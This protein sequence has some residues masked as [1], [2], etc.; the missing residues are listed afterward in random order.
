MSEDR[1]KKVA[2]A[3]FSDKQLAQDGPTGEI[4]AGEDDRRDF[5]TLKDDDPSDVL[6]KNLANATVILTS[7]DS[8]TEQ[9][10]GSYILNVSP[11]RRQDLAP[12]SGERFGNQHTGGW[13][14]GFMVGPDI[15]VTAGHCGET[16]ADI[17]DTAYV[18]G[19]RVGSEDDPGTTHFSADQVYF[20][21]E[22]IAF[23]L[24][25]SGDF[26]IVRVDRKITAADATPVQVRK[27]GAIAA[28][29]NVG[30]IGYPSGLPVKIAFGEKTVVRRV[31]DPWLICNLDTYG[32]NS[33]SA[34]F[35]SEGLVEGILVRGAQDYVIENADRCFR[36]NRIF[37]EDGT[38][39]VTKASVFVD[40]I[41]TDT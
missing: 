21:K 14:S 35:N 8:L 31:D 39:A 6:K 16:E 34:V 26:A 9:P 5:F 41:P 17:K 2:K 38:E 15:I 19:F 37:N 29:E 10:D 40:K 22:L 4:I 18:F 30:V 7:K 20:G 24:S 27:S 1:E 12:C 36:S 25:N 28:N 33:G 23:D 13:C 11:F 3:Y 32:G